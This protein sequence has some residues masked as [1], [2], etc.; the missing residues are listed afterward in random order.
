MESYKNTQNYE[1][2]YNEGAFW[3]KM[4]NITKKAGLKLIYLAFLLYYTLSS[5]T[6]STMD[7]TIIIGALGYF[8][9]PLD[10]IPDY[11]PFFGYTDDL[12]ILLY[13]YRRVKVNI[14]DDIRNNAKN[15]LS[16]FFGNYNIRDIE[17]Y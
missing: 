8:I 15:K 13:A 11:I 7:R 16:S 4:K 6:I 2:Y 17:E 10:I 3:S 1:K 14:T 12:T 9:F 5:Y